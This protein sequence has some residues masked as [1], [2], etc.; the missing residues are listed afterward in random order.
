VTVVI[1]TRDKGDSVVATVLGILAGNHP[2]FEVRIVDQSEDERTR[3][4]T[5]PLLGDPRVRYLRTDTKGL[6]RALNVGIQD[7]QSDIIAITGDDCE[8]PK[9]WLTAI[10]AAFASDSRIGI[11]F[12][13]VWPGRHDRERGFVP[14]YVREGAALAVGLGDK[15]RIGGT[16]AC[17]GLKRCVWEA[18][19]GF[20]PMLGAGA[21]FH[22]A[23]DTD[24][25]LR[26]L[27]RGYRVYE[28]PDMSVVHHGF[29]GW[30]QRLSLV[31]RYWYGSG[32]AFM[33]QLRARRWSVAIVL[34]RL[35][36]GWLSSGSRVA[37]SFGDHPHRLRGAVS[38][39]RGSLS[40]AFTP[41][42]QASG[43]YRPRD[44]TRPLP[45]TPSP[46]PLTS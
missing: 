15:H 34:L 6:S 39:V 13:N 14:G 5:E 41:V 16:S 22:S 21:R 20:D 1:P 28:T 9:G 42:D 8:I 3:T 33:K 35:A 40:G 17:M 32:A 46:S 26:A 19:G 27:S 4:A 31:H 36:G 24:L 2:D 44:S 12:G 7:S 25:T 30:D 37:R 10:A 23:E 29:Y 38:F 11:V 43:H 45:A 18:L